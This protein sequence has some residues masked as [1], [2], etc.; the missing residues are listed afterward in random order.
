VGNLCEA[1]SPPRIPRYEGTRLILD[2]VSCNCKC[3]ET[4]LES[5][6]PRCED[7]DHQVKIELADRW[8]DPLIWIDP[9]THRPVKLDSVKQVPN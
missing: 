5:K 4:V 2:R 1:C 9:K 6:G 7:C 3:K 8:E